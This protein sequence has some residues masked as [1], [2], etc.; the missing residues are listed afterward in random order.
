MIDNNE[1]VESKDTDSNIWTRLLYILL[2]AFLYSI[3][4]LA[5]F[6]VVV[7]Q[8]LF[9]LFSGERNSRVHAFAGRLSAYLYQVIRYLAFVND[10]RPFPFDDWP[11]AESD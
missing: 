2:F 5:L 10:S 6:A 7:L 4:E 8:F 9:V 11:E 3:A 1:T